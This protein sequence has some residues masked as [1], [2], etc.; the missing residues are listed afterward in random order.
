MRRIKILLLFLSIT[1]AYAP[2]AVTGL[3]VRPAYAFESTSATFELHASDIESVTGSSTSASFKLHNA[4]GQTAAAGAPATAATKEVFAGIL[5]WLYGLFTPQYEQI[6]Y[7]WRNDNG[8]E[9]TATWPFVEDTTY[10][11][12]PKTTLKRLRFEISNEGW[13][14]GTGPQFRLEVAPLS[15]TCAASTYAA[16][17]ATASSGEHWDMPLSGNFAN[18]EA[19]TNASGCSPTSDCLPDANATFTPGVMKENDNQTSALTVTSEQ[20]TEIE[21]GVQ[22]TTNATAGATYCFRLTNAGSTTNFVYYE[23]RYA[24]ATIASGY[25]VSGYIE[26]TTYDTSISNGAAYNS[27]LW[28]GSENGGNVRLQLATSNCSNGATNAPT[29]SSGAWDATGSDYLGPDCTASTFYEPNVDTPAEIDLAC[30]TVQ[31]KQYF[32][33]KVILCSNATCSG[34]GANTPA[35]T[36][37]IVN[38]SP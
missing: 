38:W 4:A 1:A 33:Y 16:V 28:N 36:G 7:R 17:P 25:P 30:A 2:L 22:A 3:L 34:T 23:T 6:H 31:N 32:R 13:T 26:S 24:K 18:N 11:G 5:H 29:C 10:T 8:S 12:F 27:L 9:T 37:V 19:T 35:V 14:R 20:F 15:G 21:Y